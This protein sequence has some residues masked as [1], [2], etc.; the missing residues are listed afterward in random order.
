MV[1]PALGPDEK[2][3]LP[4]VPAPLTKALT[5]HARGE[6]RLVKEQEGVTFRDSPS[7]YCNKRA[8]HFE[9]LID[10]ATALDVQR[11]LFDDPDGANPNA[12]AYT[13]DRLLTK[14]VVVRRDADGGVLWRTL[15]KSPLWG[16]QAR[17]FC[18]R[19]YTGFLSPEQQAQIGQVA[20]GVGGGG[21]G[22]GAG[23]C[24]APTSRARP[25]PSTAAT[26]ARRCTRTP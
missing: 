22:G 6:W 24:S 4:A 7:P 5:L 9:I 19:M 12:N 10:G 2:P 20:T 25:F 14:R 8:C 18:L 3:F 26:R 15:Y 23:G 21:G 11:V 16:I 13:F 1:A 17:D